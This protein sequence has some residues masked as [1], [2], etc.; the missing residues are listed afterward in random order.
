[1]ATVINNPTSDSGGGSVIVGVIVGAL[2]VIALL[3]YGFRK[4]GNPTTVNP[5][6]TTNTSIDI[7]LPSANS[8]VGTGTSQ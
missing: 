6:P 3:V 2:I 4:V 1:M 8:I 5:N 7:K